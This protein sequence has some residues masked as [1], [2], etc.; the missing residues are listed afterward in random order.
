MSLDGMHGLLADDL[1]Q[2]EPLLQGNV[3]IACLA[4]EGYLILQGLNGPPDNSLF[5][6]RMN[7]DIS[8]GDIIRFSVAE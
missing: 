6:Y 2:L 3:V 5:Q 1:C 7:A 4:P 8:Q